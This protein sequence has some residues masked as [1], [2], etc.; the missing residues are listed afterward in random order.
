MERLKS[1][2]EEKGKTQAQMAEIFH[3]S[4]QVYA[5]Y[6]NGVNEPS[7][8]TLIAI[9]DYFC[10]S[11]DYLLG[12][13]DEFGNVTILPDY[14]QQENFSSDERTLLKYF[15]NL[16]PPYKKLLLEYVSFLEEKHK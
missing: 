6:E 13:S 12:R 7:Q 1:L 8:Q 4:R 2:R 16:T 3:I 5:N 11:I 14:Q 10:C 9:A 15:R